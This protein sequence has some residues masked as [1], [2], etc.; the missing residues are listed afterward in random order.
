MAKVGDT[1]RYLNANGGGKIVRIVDKMAYV[2]DDGFEMPVLLKELVVVQPV[3]T[4]PSSAHLIFDQKAYDKG[5]EEPQ[6]PQ[7][8]KEIKKSEP[9]V[10]PKPEPK[11]VE[12]DYGEK[13]NIL[14]AFEP[15][16]IKHLD[17]SRFEALLVNDSNYTLDFSYLTRSS[18]ARLWNLGFHG[19]VPANELISLGVY[20][21]EELPQ[22]ERIAIHYIALKTDKPFEMKAPGAVVR[23]LDLTKFY[24]LHCFRKG[25]YFDTPVLEVPIVTDDVA[26]R[27]LQINTSEVVEAMNLPQD[28]KQLKE[29]TEKYA[30]KRPAKVADP[31]SN[32]HKLLPPVEVDLHINQLLDTTAG[33][34]NTDMLMHQLSVVRK[35]MDMHKK[36]IGQK[37]IF[38]HGKGDGVLRKAV[39]DLLKKEYSKCTLQDASFAEYGF[40]A[41]LVTVH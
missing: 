2:E 24:K 29:L 23:R 26:A 9:E 28:K 10:A 30:K 39:I 36:R 21:R 17:K 38:I 4:S 12:T 18:E 14:L 27:T 13:L 11:P 34:T 32:P 15:T 37:I 8:S 6:E 7:F 1:V 33:M 35:T 5:R 3:G 41:T 19:T 25:L 20:A 31:A 16:D 40:G 22:I